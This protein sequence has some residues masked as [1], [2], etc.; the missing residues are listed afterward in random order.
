MNDFVKQYELYL[1]AVAR[2]NELNKA[3]VF[4]A[5]A[6]AGLTSVTVEFDGE[7]DSGQINGM[8]A[9]AGESPA[10]LPSTS[11]KLQRAPQNG[12]DLRTAEATLRDAIETLCYDY[13]TQCH[14]GWENNDGA[15]GTFEFD[16][17]NRTVHLDIDERFTDTTNS[18]HEF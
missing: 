6:A 12:G 9:H 10:E 16:V 8:A 13:L 14:D 3:A 18:T 7:G 2:A 15:Y 17:P 1:K 4:E 5:L 11:L